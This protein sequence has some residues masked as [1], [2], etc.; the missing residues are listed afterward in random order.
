MSLLDEEPNMTRQAEEP[1]VHPSA[2]A[3]RLHRGIGMVFRP[4][5][6]LET[7]P[8]RSGVCMRVIAPRFCRNC[9]QTRSTRW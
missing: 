8:M 6:S 4:H 2:V 9:P 3:A 7:S 5:S 1:E